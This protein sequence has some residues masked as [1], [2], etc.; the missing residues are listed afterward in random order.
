LIAASFSVVWVVAGHWIKVWRAQRMVWGL[1]E[2]G[3]VEPLRT[4]DGIRWTSLCNPSAEA[5]SFGVV[6][7]DMTAL[8]S[9]GWAR[10]LTKCRFRNI[11]VL[12]AC[13]VYEALTGRVHP[14]W[15]HEGDLVGVRIARSMSLIKRTLDWCI[16]L[17]LSPLLLLLT[18]ICAVAI[19]LDSRGPVFFRQDR[20]G[21]DNHTFRVCKLRTMVMEHEGNA[22][23][24]ADEWD[25]R[26][27]RVG[28]ILR[29]CRLDEIPQFWNVV[30]GEM[31]IVGPRPEQREFVDQFVES[32]PFYALRHLVRPGITGWAQVHYGYAADEIENRRKL[33]FDLFYLKHWSFMLD[34]MILMRTIVVVLT[35]RGAR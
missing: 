11:P 20:V 1:V 12:N 7:V 30:K 13:R 6:V 35:G 16:C 24:F 23:S 27:T 14:E 2:I 10:F 29:K 5:S 32:I 19:K 33:E 8:L 34:T 15:V 17:L 28:R 9:P 18:G 31:S 22:A 21:L 26:I 25:G 4:L 3:C